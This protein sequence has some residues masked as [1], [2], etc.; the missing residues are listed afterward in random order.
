MSDW[1]KKEEWKAPKTEEERKKYCNG[2]DARGR[3]CKRVAR[4][5]F[6]RNEKWYCG[7]HHPDWI[8]DRE[9]ARAE[10]S[11]KK[12]AVRARNEMLAILARAPYEDIAAEYEKRKK[13][14]AVEEN[15]QRALKE[16]K[17]EG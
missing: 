17:E 11:A 15:L 5:F 13:Q 16:V 3:K 1:M 4:Y 7:I 12:R 9:K 10:K 14:L 2:R 6:E 8:A